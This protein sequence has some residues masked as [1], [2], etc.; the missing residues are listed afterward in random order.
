MFQIKVGEVCLLTSDVIRYYDDALKK[1]TEKV[2]MFSY[3]SMLEDFYGCNQKSYTFAI[4][5]LINGSFGINFVDEETLKYL[6]WD[7]LKTIDDA[8][9][10]IIDY[11]WSQQASLPL[12]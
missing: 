4:T 9:M 2:N 8:K 7:G 1:E 3:V 6:F 12:N 10:A 11:Y 5:G